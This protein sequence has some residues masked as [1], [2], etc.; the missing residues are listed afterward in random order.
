MAKLKIPGLSQ[1]FSSAGGSQT[2]MI[3]AAAATAIAGYIGYTY[4]FKPDVDSQAVAPAAEIEMIGS[5]NL[6]TLEQQLVNA[7]MQY[8]QNQDT[9]YNNVDRIKTAAQTYR[10]KLEELIKERLGGRLNETQMK[11]Q[12]TEMVKEIATM[13]EIPLRSGTSPPNPGPWNYWN[14]HLQCKG[15][16]RFSECRNACINSFEPDP[17]WCP[18]PR[19]PPPI[20]VPPPPVYPPYPGPYP[21]PYPRPR[22]P[23]FP[24][25]PRR[26]WFP[27]RRPRPYPRPIPLPPPPPVYR[28]RRRP[29]PRPVYRPRPRPRPRPRGNFNLA[30][31]IVINGRRINIPK[32]NI[33]KINFPKGF[34]F[35]RANVARAYSTSGGGFG[36][37]CGVPPL[38]GY[39][40]GLTGKTIVEAQLKVARSHMDKAVD[41]CRGN[42]LGDK[43]KCKVYTAIAT[44]WC[45]NAQSHFN[46]KCERRAPPPPPVYYPP[47]PVYVP[48]PPIHHPPWQPP[49]HECWNCPCPPGQACND[50]C[51]PEIRSA[52]LPGVVR[53]LH[54]P[55]LVQ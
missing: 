12:L 27:P 32:I 23:L 3:I 6:V 55:V 29:R 8:A 49:Q 21:H 34:P 25:R 45:K 1:A 28:P 16:Q 2:N 35:A 43:I 39:D 50:M 54:I 22:P 30:R 47:P 51:Y 52:A 5:T 20:F 37:N 15:G 46:S 33:P 42:S 26:P 17:Y 41:A 24:P 4:L 48:P 40:C 53:G 38:I 9:V 31:N 18:H 10:I 36:G 7:V 19:P 11:Q 14:E 13:L 44:T